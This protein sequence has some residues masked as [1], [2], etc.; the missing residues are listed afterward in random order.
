MPSQTTYKN[1]NFSNQNCPKDTPVFNPDSSGKEKDSETGYHYFGARYYNSDLSL[2]LSVDP[3]SDKYPGLSPYNYCAWNPMKLVDPDGMELEANTDW[4]KNNKTGEIGWQEGHSKQIVDKNGNTY[5]NIGESYSK[6]IGDGRYENYYQNC[7]VSRGEKQDAS[8][9]AHNNKSIFNA[10]ISKKSPLPT[11]HKQDLFNRHVAN[12]G[13]YSPDM[14]GV[15]FSGNLFVGGGL[16]IEFGGGVIKGD[17]LYG[18]VSLSPGSGFDISGSAGLSVGRYYGIETPSK[19][20]YSGLSYTISVG[21]GGFFYQHNA[22]DLRGHGWN[23][24]TLGVSIGSKIILGG[25]FGVSH[26][27]V[28]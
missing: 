21:G 20:N 12:R 10:L 4:Y 27:W 23:V 26:T 1:T 3:M 22:S 11:S 15:Q 18:S 16:S 5:S 25:S 28:W 7:L 14:L 19:S 13:G 9:L 6:P 8:R 2:W 17:G 24:S